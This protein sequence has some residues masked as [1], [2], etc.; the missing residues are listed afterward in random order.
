MRKCVRQLF[1]LTLPPLLEWLTGLG[2][3]GRDK[4][5]LRDWIAHLA[6]AEGVSLAVADEGKPRPMKLD[7]T[8]IAGDFNFDMREQG[9]KNRQQLLSRR[10]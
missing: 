9:H 6:D 7:R 4:L 2:E 3:S 1:A 10:A 8:I 5:E